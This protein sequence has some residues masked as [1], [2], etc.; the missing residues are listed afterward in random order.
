[1]SGAR[2]AASL[3]V[4]VTAAGCVDPEQTY[5][6]FLD[7]FAHVDS[8]LLDGAGTLTPD[9]GC[10]LP[11]PD[12]VDGQFLF[13]VSIQVAPKTP[14]LYLLDA[15][16]VVDGDGLQVTTVAHPLDKK[17]RHTIVG[18]ATNV[19][20]AHYR[21]AADGNFSADLPSTITPDLAEPVTGQ[22]VTSNL[23]L[24]GRS[25]SERTPE[26]PDS[27]IDFTCGT[28]KI[29]IDVPTVLD[30]TGTFTTTRVTDPN[31][32]PDPVIDCAKTAANPAPTN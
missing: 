9:G 8:G 16:H 11:P 31:K 7:R 32:Y 24:M 1:M 29:H 12:E 15:T 28:L 17:D 18:D 25:C 13:V 30:A 5:D 10:K 26:H 14:I 6:D 19:V 23:T 2:V 3:F 4:L 22:N 20:T 27:T 21:I